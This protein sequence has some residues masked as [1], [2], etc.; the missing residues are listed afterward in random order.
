MSNA[1]YTILAF[2]A[3]IG[4]LWT[5]MVQKNQDPNDPV[6]GWLVALLCFVLWPVSVAVGVWV[7]VNQDRYLAAVAKAETRKAEER[8]QFQ[9]NVEAAREQL[10][11]WVAEDPENRR[12]EERD[13]KRG[14]EFHMVDDA[15][16]HGWYETQDKEDFEDFWNGS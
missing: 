12:F 4:G 1:V 2:Y 15:H 13:G 10:N 7:T 9:A 8:A 14:R 11:A 3:A 5:Y 16:E 6:D